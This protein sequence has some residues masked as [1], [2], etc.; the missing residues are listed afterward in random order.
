[1]LSFRRA[2][3]YMVPYWRWQAAA[4]ICALAVTAAEFVWPWMN[5]VLIDEVMIGK[6][7]E[8][9]TRIA[10]L[11]RLILVTASAFVA[12]TALNLTRAYLFARVSECAAADLRHDLFQHVHF[13]PMAY[14]DRR[15]T[16]GIMSVV[17][18]DVEALQGLYASTLVEIVT[19]V[20]MVIVASALLIW[21]SPTLAAIGLPVPVAFAVALALFG[22]PL[23]AAGRRVRDDTAALQEVLQESIAGAREVRLFNRGRAELARYMARVMPLVASR[24][25]QTVL[26][27]ANGAL[28]RLIAMGGMTIVLAVGA[29]L[30]IAGVMSAGDVV[31]FLTVLGM[32]FG[33]ASTFVNLYAGIAVAMGA[34]DRIF[35]FLDA[36]ME[37][38]PETPVRLVAGP[39]PHDEPAVSFEQVSF[40]Y[41][42]TGSDVLR[43]IDLRIGANEVVALVGPSGSGK[44]TLVSLIPRLYDATHGVVRVFGQDVRTL[45]LANLRARIAFVPQEPYL[46]GT[47]VAEN[48]GFGREGAGQD[49]IEEAARAANAHEFI[50]A[51][52]EGYR[53]QVGERGARLSVGQKQRIAIARAFLRDPG[54]LILDEATSAQDAESERLVQEAMTRLMQG[55]AAIVIAHRLS[56]VQRA[57]RIVVLEAGRIVEQGPHVELVQSGGL[58]ARLHSMQLGAAQPPGTGARN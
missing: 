55:R 51:L 45:S 16:G 28:A 38:E 11:H 10:A 13:L 33:P 36:E 52:P 35:E 32:L 46:F 17:Q 27:A 24:I 6:G 7:A 34:A 37:K 20:L 18:N 31:L 57:D 44:T 5:K 29:R 47:T 21:R 40:Q 1:M 30:A 14:Y 15:K 48:I 58:Y 49:E 4:L 3:R 2:L 8:A 12:G 25:R 39:V 50:V 56:T 42:G 53:T 26:G 43:G 41:D 22:K 23:R 9:A 54:F 19:N